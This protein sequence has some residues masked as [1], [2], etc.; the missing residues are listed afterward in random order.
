MEDNQPQRAMDSYG[1]EELS[2]PIV[3]L[4]Q[5]VGSEYAKDA[6]DASPGDLFFPLTNQVIPGDQG[7][8][9][10]LVD[11]LKTRTFWGR[12]ELDEDPPA[13]SSL[14]GVTAMDGTDCATCP[15]KHDAPWL[16]SKDERRTMCLVNYN[17][18]AFELTNGL[19]LIIRCHGISCQ[20]ARDLLTQLKMNRT[21]GGQYHRAVI[22]VGSAKKKTTSGEA[23]LFKFTVKQFIT[24]EK[25]A[26]QYLTETVRLLGTQLL[27]AGTDEQM[28]DQIEGAVET[29]VSTPT[30]TPTPGKDLFPQP[31]KLLPG[32]ALHRSVQVLSDPSLKFTADGKAL[33]DFK[34]LLDGNPIKVVAWENLAEDL[35]QSNIR[36]GDFVEVHGKIKYRTYQ[37]EEI[38][39]LVARE[40]VPLKAEA[41]KTTQEPATEPKK[42]KAKPKEPEE[43]PPPAPVEPMP[44]LDF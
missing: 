41:P 35:S 7:I 8:D 3:K 36:S 30:S 38:I 24:D 4:V 15:H 39:E 29:P 2:I 5:N 10:I 31:I 21:L 18:L 20:A 22:H 12:V 11:M 27:P 14:D 1:A 26:K 13:C 6:L 43:N 28:V 44:D 19:P 17:V 25:T 42:A 37:N 16:L 33:C 9:I 23:Y 32:Q 40:I 34:S